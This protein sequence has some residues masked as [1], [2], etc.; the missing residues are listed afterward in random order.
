MA[1]ARFV[2]IVAVVSPVA[3]DTWTCRLP[4]Q[5]SNVPVVVDEESLNAIVPVASVPAA[6]GM[7]TMVKSKYALAL[8]AAADARCRIEP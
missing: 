1:A 4:I 3:T 5:Q 6:S 2:A 8:R 7:G